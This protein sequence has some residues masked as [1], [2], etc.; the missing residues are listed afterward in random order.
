MP[1][2]T[3]SVEC[4]RIIQD[5]GTDQDPWKCHETNHERWREPVLDSERTAHEQQNGTTGRPES[6][7]WQWAVL[8]YRAHVHDE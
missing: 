8:Q 4:P 7:L 1:S 5:Q 3:Q 6:R 2:G